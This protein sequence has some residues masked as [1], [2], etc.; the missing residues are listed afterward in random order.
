MLLDISQKLLIA[1]FK[2]L[3]KVWRLCWFWIWR[4]YHC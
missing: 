3:C 1:D 4:L 2:V